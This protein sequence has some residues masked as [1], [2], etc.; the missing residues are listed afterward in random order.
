M[1]LSKLFHWRAGH[2]VNNY[3]LLPTNSHSGDTSANA[4]DHSRQ[5]EAPCR[6]SLRSIVATLAAGVILWILYGLWTRHSSLPPSGI[7]STDDGPEPPTSS[8]DTDIPQ[9]PP[10]PPP[11]YEEYREQE[12]NFPQHNLSLPYPDGSHAKFLWAANHGSC[13]NFCLSHFHD[14]LTAND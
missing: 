2:P 11:L 7:T 4:A 14:I 8:S 12:R 3:E 9:S 6:L 10:Q 5:K 1:I 13:T